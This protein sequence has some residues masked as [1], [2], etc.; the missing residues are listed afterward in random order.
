MQKNSARLRSYRK[1]MQPY[2]GSESAVAQYNFLQEVETHRFLFRV[3]EDQAK[4][5]EH[6]QT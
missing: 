6:I 1:A 5:S 4:L 2:I 3:L